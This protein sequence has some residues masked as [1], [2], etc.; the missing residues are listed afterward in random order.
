MNLKK[1]TLHFIFFVSFLLMACSFQ[2]ENEQPMYHVSKVADA[3]NFSERLSTQIQNV[4][5]LI[6]SKPGVYSDAISFLIDMRIPS[7]KFRFFV[8]DLAKD[9]VLL[10]GLVAHGAGSETGKADS[11]QFSNVPNSYMTSLGNYKIGY[12]YAGSFGKSY[13]LFGLDASNS[14]AFDRLVVLHPYHC[15]PDTE[16]PYPICNSLGCAMVSPAFL[17]H[18]SSFIEKQKKPILLRIYY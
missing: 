16:Q 4:E 14:K 9:S 15:V 12:S 17:T 10:K 3:V 2:K 7:N 8:V 13:K 5:K 18:L 1:H 6:L 11:L